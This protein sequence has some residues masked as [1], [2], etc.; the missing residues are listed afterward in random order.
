MRPVYAVSRI[1]RNLECEFVSGV[2][3]GISPMTRGHNRR[4]WHQEQVYPHMFWG[5]GW[6][7]NSVR[8]RGLAR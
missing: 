2:L 7:V 4:H 8:E 3:P 6:A 1:D 5:E